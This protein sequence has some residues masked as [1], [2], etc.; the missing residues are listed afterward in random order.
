MT[1]N[2]RIEMLLRAR[3][4]LHKQENG[5]GLTPNEIVIAHDLVDMIVDD[6]CEE[7]FYKKSKKHKNKW[8]DKT[9]TAE[10]VTKA[11]VE[12]LR[13]MHKTEMR[14]QKTIISCYGPVVAVHRMDSGGNLLG[15]KIQE[16]PNDF[17]WTALEMMPDWKEVL[18]EVYKAII[19]KNV[20]KN[21]TKKVTKK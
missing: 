5:E 12:I 20:T 8:E 15:V 18:V 10:Q 17:Y 13:D 16:G 3:N 1:T 21:V 7:E 6:L 14:I 11:I 19:P 9:M 2:E 4:I